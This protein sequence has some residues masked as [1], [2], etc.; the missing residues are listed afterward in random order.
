V[1]D[2]K[3]TT[4]AQDAGFPKYA[5]LGAYHWAEVSGHWVRHHAFTAERYRRA[6]AALGPLESSSV[7]DY[8]CGDGALIGWILRRSAACEVHGYDANPLAVALCR[9]KLA[10]EGLTATIHE[11][12]HELPDERFDAII[13]A[14]V[15]EHVHDPAA[16]LAAI[17]RLLKPGGRAVITTPVRLTHHPEDPSHVREWFFDEFRALVDGGPLTVRAHESLIPAAATEIYFWRPRFLLRV[18][19]FRLLCNL[20]SIYG[21]VNALSWL[22]V[23]PRLFMMQQAVLDKP[24]RPDAPHA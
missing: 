22:K 24:R 12:L 7:L 23:R 18:P 20:L 17:A 15:I 13:C 2:S 9:Q 10:A 3:S 4:A 21:N 1:P 6:L 16:L 11:S 14:E 5:V 19:L 8:G